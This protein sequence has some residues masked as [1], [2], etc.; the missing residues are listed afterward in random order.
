MFAM[1]AHHEKSLMPAPSL[2][3]V[4]GTVR[5]ESSAILAT[6]CFLGSGLGLV[7]AVRGQTP[8]SENCETNTACLALYEQAQS[9]SK[10]GQLTEALRS[11]KLAYEVQHDARLLFSIARLLHKSGK[12]AEAVTYYQRFISSDVDDPAQK[13]KAWEYISQIV[14]RKPAVTPGL[15]KEMP[16]VSDLPRQQPPSTASA[17]PKQS[18]TL[19]PIVPD[20]QPKVV[21]QLRLPVRR[22]RVYFDLGFG[23]TGALISSGVATEVAWF[24]NPRTTKYEQAR[25]SSTGFFWGGLGLRIEAG[26]FVW[27]GLSIGVS[28]RFEAYSNHNADS[29]EAAMKNNLCVESQGRPSPCFATTAKGQYGYM[30]LGKLRYQFSPSQVFR[31]YVHIDIGGGQWR[32]TLNIDGLRPVKNGAIDSES[33]LQPTDQCSAEY[34]G[35]AD[36]ERKPAGCTSVGGNLGYNQQTGTASATYV[37]RVCPAT[38]S[39]VDSVLLGRLF[40]GAGAGFYVGG[41]H[42]GVSLDVDLLTSLSGTT[43]LLIDAYLGPQFMF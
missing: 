39:C 21:E 12:E 16:V 1:Q 28:G 26:A 32:S 27:R 9:Q 10:A 36:P 5:R 35:K 4:V 41:R 22:D 17:V 3:L 25:S 40:I 2:R 7:G 24:Y 19:D 38:G 8:V 43:G 23:T 33:P 20:T 11:Y 37:N 34:N 18:S 42:A 31:P 30:V 29:A 13:D 15:E 14:S 6:I